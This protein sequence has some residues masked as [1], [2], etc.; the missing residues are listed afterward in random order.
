MSVFS[1]NFPINRHYGNPQNSETH[2]LDNLWYTF[3]T[4]YKIVINH[5]RDSFMLVKPVYKDNLIVDF[6]VADANQILLVSMNATRNQIIGVGI[7]DLF[8]VASQSD[9]FPRFVQ[10]FETK[11]PYTYEYELFENEM[12]PYGAYR[13]EVYPLDG[14]LAI[15]NVNL[16]K[17]VM[18]EKQIVELHFERERVKLLQEFIRE[19]GHDIK[20]PLSV[21]GTSMYLVERERDFDKMTDRIE[22]IKGQ[23]AHINAIVDDLVRLTKWKDDVTYSNMKMTYMN[24]F[25]SNIVNDLRVIAANKNQTLTLNLSDNCTSMIDP[26][27]MYRAITNVIRNAIAYTPEGGAIQVSVRQEGD[28]VKIDVSDN[29]M[30]I[31]EDKLSAIFDRFYRVNANVV[32]VDGNS[33]LGLTIAR[34]IIESHAGK[35]SVA[36]K[37]GIGST[38]TISLSTFADNM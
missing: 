10:S 37:M 25:V 2:P 6:T 38:F 31:P 18:A 36:S 33:G 1:T 4:L 16:T 8:P 9:F 21:I 19:A 14:A 12:Q 28:C 7:L 5:S 17:I 15:I 22:V 34:E 20:T 23:I 29:G 11:E 30:G 32:A 35:I 24:E 3:K 13:V 27:K 26:E